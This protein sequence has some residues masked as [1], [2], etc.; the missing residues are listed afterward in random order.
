LYF[1]NLYPSRFVKILRFQHNEVCNLIRQFRD[2]IV[3]LMWIPTLENGHVFAAA[4]KYGQVGLY[5]PDKFSLLNTYSLDLRTPMHS[6]RKKLSGVA[7]GDMK[8]RLR[9]EKPP[10]PKCGRTHLI[11][12]AVYARDAKSIVF[13]TSKS[14]LQWYNNEKNTGV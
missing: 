13:A 9:L 2:N 10:A 8:N 14:I 5:D 6:Q 12:D 4:D 11:V 7:Y 1:C 3:R